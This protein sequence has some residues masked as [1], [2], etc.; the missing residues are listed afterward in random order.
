MSKIIVTPLNWGLG[1]ASRCVPI[2]NHLIENRFVPV[3][4]SDGKALEFLSKEFPDLETL[5]LPSYNISYG[6][7][8]KWNLFKKI[9]AI[10][11]AIK[12][13]RRILQKYLTDNPEVTG[14]ISD[15]RFGMYAENIPSVYIT[16]QVKVLSGVFTPLTSYFH[17]KIIKRFD[18]C[19]VPDEL[20]SKFSGNLSRSHKRLNKKHIGILSRFQKKEVEKTIDILIVLSG[21][22]PNRS[23]L[24]L[25]LKQIFRH[26][27][28]NIWLIQGVVE[29]EQTMEEL[30]N[31]RTINFMLSEELERTMNSANL[32]IC[33]SGYSSIMD[34]IILNKKALLIPTKNQSEQEYLAKFLRAQGFFDFVEEDNLNINLLKL[35]E[36]K[37]NN[38]FI[39]KELDANLFNLF[40]E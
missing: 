18:E 27:Q 37:F 32:I 28:Q 38:D 31:L 35:P 39:K 10:R 2:I 8:L 22:E 19:W 14:V 21:P 13:E 20:N 3:L 26:S 23:Q 34:L 36:N 25:K 4:A 5:Q 17:Q 16:H 15:N 9:G 24:E 1:H 30:G 12:K 29:S 33:R 11:K 7:N 6:R 40:R